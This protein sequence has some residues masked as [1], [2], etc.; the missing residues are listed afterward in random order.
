MLGK[1]KELEGRP[2]VPALCQACVG[3]LGSCVTLDKY[4]SLSV[5]EFPHAQNHRLNLPFWFSTSPGAS[6]LAGGTQSRHGGA[7]GEVKDHFFLAHRRRSP[8]SLW[9]VDCRVP[10]HQK[11]GR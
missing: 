4:L 2:K 10:F 7:C 9:Y 6:G 3:A 11:E 8:L 5:L 1:Q